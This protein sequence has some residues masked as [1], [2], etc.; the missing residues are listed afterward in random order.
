[1]IGLDL[2]S[3]IVGIIEGESKSLG[4]TRKVLKTLDGFALNK[5]KSPER[6]GDESIVFLFM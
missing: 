4:L 5:E 1:M 6:V 2:E 3:V